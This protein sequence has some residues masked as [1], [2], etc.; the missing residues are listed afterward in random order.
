[1]S[2]KRGLEICELS[3]TRE[4]RVTRGI[5]DEMFRNRKVFF[6]SEL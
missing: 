5:D 3:V 4:L 6:I 1:M 2:N